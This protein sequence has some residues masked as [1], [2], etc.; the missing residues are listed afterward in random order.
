MMEGGGERMTHD[1]ICTVDSRDQ[2]VDECERLEVESGSS[3]ESESHRTHRSD[4]CE[5]EVEDDGS[6]VGLNG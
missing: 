1:E 4:G 2:V 3:D 6:P 5:A